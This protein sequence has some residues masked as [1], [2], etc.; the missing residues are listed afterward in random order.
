M[1]ATKSHPA[2]RKDDLR[3]RY[4]DEK[5]ILERRRKEVIRRLHFMSEYD[6]MMAMR[7]A[8]LYS[9]RTGDYDVIRSIKRMKDEL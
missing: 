1:N 9:H 2:T 5:K 8:G 3:Y 6:I 4:K 7:R